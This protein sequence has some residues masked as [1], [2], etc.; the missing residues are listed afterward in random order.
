M[1]CTSSYSIFTKFIRK[2]DDDNYDVSQVFSDECYEFWLSTRVQVPVAPEESYRKAI[3]SHVK[4]VGGRRPF[5]KDIEQAFLKRLREKRIWKCFEKSAV[6]IGKR[7]YR[8]KGYWER[9]TAESV[10]EKEAKTRPWVSSD[11]LHRQAKRLRKLN[12]PED[13]LMKRLD[14][15]QTEFLDK[16]VLADS[17]DSEHS[18][19]IDDNSESE[20]AKVLSQANVMKDRFSV[21]GLSFGADSF[22]NGSTVCPTR[23]RKDSCRKQDKNISSFDSPSVMQDIWY[24]WKNE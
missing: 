19:P 24:F 14:M 20:S 5:P 10:G 22:K 17:S 2:L 7:G 9:E 6:A 15:F 8:A 12:A 18:F 23:E 21:R 1:S 4:G 11:S 16:L 13:P 3:T